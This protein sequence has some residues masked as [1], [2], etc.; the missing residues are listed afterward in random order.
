MRNLVVGAALTAALAFIP[1]PA[2]AEMSEIAVAQQYGISYLPLMLMEEQKLIEKYAKAAGVD[3]NVKWAK[4]AGGNV[5]NDA[6][7]SGSLQFASGGVGPLITIWAKTKGNL[8]VKGVASL[9]SM[10]LY[11]NTRN[12]NVKTI[13]D[14]TDKDRI[15]L[16]AV[17][18]SIQAVTLQMAAEKAFGEG[19]QGKLDPLTVTMSHPDG[20]TALLSGKSE[21]T[22][23]F[24]S[25][26]FQY[27]QL[28]RPGIHTV[29]NSFDVLGGP[30]TF[31]CIW[32]TAKFRN[33]NPKLYDAFLKGLDDAIAQINK[34]K[35]AAAEAYLRISKD[36]DTVADILAMLNDPQIR[37][38]TVP[39]NVMAYASFMTKI[40]MIKVKPDSWKDIF[41]PNLHGVAG[42]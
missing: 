13:K 15:A 38:T 37:Y 30:A 2:R 41:F 23:H 20:Q 9:N 42:S 22:A 8:D 29:L 36:K 31:N 5:M 17:K 10:P 11:L 33:E 6:L 12:P 1:L 14:F 32:T 34:D 21:I 3:V 27:Q 40:G 7:L 25:P 18:V 16:P 26:P 28:E 39:L 19:Q 4:F 24:S 35:K